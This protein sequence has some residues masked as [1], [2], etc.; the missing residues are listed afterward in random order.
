M[1]AL[2]LFQTHRRRKRGDERRVPRSEKARRDIPQIRK[3][4]GPNPVSF[5]IFR[6]FWGYVGHTADVSSPT[7]K[8]V[9]TPLFSRLPTFI[10]I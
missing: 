2:F 4:S 3:R 10:A 7:K 6:I 9:T 5:L 1:I 8:S